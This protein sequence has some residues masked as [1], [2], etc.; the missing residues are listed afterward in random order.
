MV[1]RRS[2]IVYFRNPKVLK[3][4]EKVA[5][6]KYYTKKKKYAIIYV[7][8]EEVKAKKEELQQLK[9]VRRVDESLFDTEEYN[10]EF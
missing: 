3:Q 6:I 7:S 5:E 2:L 10:L 8:E 4:V 1:K 9:L